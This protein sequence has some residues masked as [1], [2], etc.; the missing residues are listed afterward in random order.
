MIGVG[1]VSALTLEAAPRSPY[2]PSEWTDIAD[3]FDPGYPY[4]MPPEYQDYPVWDGSP[5]LGK[6]DLVS[7]GEDSTATKLGGGYR[8]FGGTSAA[9]PRVAG[10]VALMLQ[11]VPDATP[12]ELAAAL[13]STARDLG[14]AGRDLRYGVGLPDATAA[15]AALGPPLSIDE[16]EILDTGG[17][18]GD[19]DGAPDEGEINRLRIALANSSGTPLEGV[20]LVLGAVSGARVRDGFAR[21]PNVPA[22][23]VASTE[24]PHL[25]VEFLAGSCGALAELT[26]EI[27][28]EGRSRA[29]S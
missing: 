24:A 4:E 28:H 21:L 9:T 6:P 12:A 20:E 3:H 13:L 17:T 1:N 25:G 27:R 14:P 22:G 11:A 8:V 23:G 5:G 29:R 2:G 18:R 16:W 15:I 10:I 26:L 7:I 19:G